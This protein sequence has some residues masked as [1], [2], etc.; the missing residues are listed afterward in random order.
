MD[1]CGQVTQKLHL[2]TWDFPHF[3]NTYECDF[4]SQ[5]ALFTTFAT[6]STAA[7][8]QSAAEVCITPDKS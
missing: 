6:I 2:T 1:C 5:E 8:C 4:T 7:S 3:T